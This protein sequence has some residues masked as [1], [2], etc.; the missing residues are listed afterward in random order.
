MRMAN[1]SGSMVA[2]VTKV[3]IDPTNSRVLTVAFKASA[4]NGLR[5]TLTITPVVDTTKN[6][7]EGD[8][9]VTLRGTSGDIL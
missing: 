2:S 5:R 7:K 4:D 9:T 3:E 1:V 6:A 8:L